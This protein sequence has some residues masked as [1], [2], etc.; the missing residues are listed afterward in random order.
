[1]KVFDRV[2]PVI[3]LTISSQTTL[4]VVRYIR[5][6]NEKLLLVTKTCKTGLCTS[7]MYCEVHDIDFTAS[8]HFV[9]VLYRSFIYLVMKGFDTPVYHFIT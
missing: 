6:Y 4:S 5:R 8:C 9:T 2:K 1:M 7:Y 3:L